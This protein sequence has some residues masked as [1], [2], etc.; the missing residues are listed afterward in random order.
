MEKIKIAEFSYDI[1]SSLGEY[2]TPEFDY[3]KTLGMAA[4]LAVHIRGLGEISYEVLKLASFHYFKIPSFA[5][6]KVIDILSELE[7]VDVLGPKKKIKSIIP[8]IPHFASIY[9]T[10]GE[11]TEDGDLNES[12]LAMLAILN[13]VYNKPENKQKLINGV[14]AESSII[15]ICLKYSEA[16]GLLRTHKARG[17]EIIL[18]P[19]YFSDNLDGLADLTAKSGSSNILRVLDKLKANQG[20]PLSMVMSNKEI[21]GQKLD[22]IELSLINSMSAEGI[23]KPPSIKFGNGNLEQFIFTPNPGS[24]RLNAANREIYERSMALVSSVRKGQLM[25][26]RYRINYPIA[27]LK[28]LRNKGFL[29]SNSEASE[30][31][32]NLVFMKVAFLRPVGSK[33][34]LVLIQ[35]EENVQALDIAI[36]LLETGELASLEVNKEATISFSKDE[37]YVQSIMAA[38]E[39]RK[40]KQVDIAEEAKHEMDQLLL[41]LDI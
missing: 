9:S 13:Q 36:N 23:L 20:W 26:A 35:S 8:K 3:L 28:S 14:G 31:Y 19:Y 18:S 37:V 1:H 25:P 4:T 30:Q 34:Q 27:I 41:N 7:F 12:E 21:G 6:D 29:S 17:K 11:F 38:S 39:M 32:K 24:N 33:C 22:H 5:L 2:E 40:R 16:G 15:D 10:I